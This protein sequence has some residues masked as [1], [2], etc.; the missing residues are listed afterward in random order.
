MAIGGACGFGADLLRQMYEQRNEPLYTFNFDRAITVGLT[1]TLAAPTWD[2]LEP[3]TTPNH[4]G[5]FHS[6][7]C[8][9]LVTW[10]AWGEPS[11]HLSPGARNF[12]QSASFGALSHSVVD[13][14]SPKGIPLV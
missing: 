3:A 4:R 13:G 14:F 11:R 7:A 6:V 1:A 12:L 2:L 5:F 8:M 9:A 10:A